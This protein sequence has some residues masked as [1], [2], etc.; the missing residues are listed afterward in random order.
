MVYRHQY[1]QLDTEVKKVFD[2]NGKELRLTGNTYRVLVFLCANKH[3]NITEIGEFLDWAKDYDENHLR[4]YKYK[5]NTVIGR[6]V[7]D[8]KNGIYSIIGETK[9]ADKLGN[10]DRNKDLLRSSR[11]KSK[12]SSSTKTMGQKNILKVPGVIAIIMLFLTFFNWPYAYYNLLRLVVTAASLYYAY[13]LGSFFKKY[14]FWFWSMLAIA[15]IFN[16]LI[17]IYL[18]QKG[19]WI[20][21]DL[22]SMIIFL[23]FIFYS[24]K[25]DGE[26]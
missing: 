11:L 17:P 19:L 23:A 6:D 21:L 3:G 14:N 26:Y 12:A 10:I 18:R 20:L 4:Q 8:Y 7:I 5:I 22:I 9:E 1:F 13:F 15:T 25:Q 16:P 24:K 2:E